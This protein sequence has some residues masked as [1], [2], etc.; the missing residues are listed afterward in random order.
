[1]TEINLALPCL[2]PWNLFKFSELLDNY[3]ISS[4]KRDKKGLY[5]EIKVGHLFS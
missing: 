1:M 3:F 2:I 4:N 5:R